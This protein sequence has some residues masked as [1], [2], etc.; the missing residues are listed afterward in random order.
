MSHGKVLELVTDIKNE[1]GKVFPAVPVKAYLESKLA[2][3]KAAIAK[4]EEPLPRSVPRQV[5]T[6]AQTSVLDPGASH[7]APTTEIT[8]VTVSELAP[9]LEHQL[10]I[11]PQSAST[12]SNESETNASTASATA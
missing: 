11:A 5:P 4:I 6:A 2:E 8:G 7:P 3:L 9:A 1:F 10:P 12:L